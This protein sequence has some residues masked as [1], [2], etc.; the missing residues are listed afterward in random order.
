MLLFHI[1]FHNR[2]DFEAAFRPP[3]FISDVTPAFNL[4]RL[5][6][7]RGGLFFTNYELLL[8][9]GVCILVYIYYLILLLARNIEIGLILD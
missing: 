8:L 5:L 2:N 6:K 9:E 7:N 3:G 4:N 1:S